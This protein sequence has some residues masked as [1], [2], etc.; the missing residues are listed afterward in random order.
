MVYE[1]KTNTVNDLHSEIKF[2][3]YEEKDLHNTRKKLA[4]SK[5]EKIIKEK[6]YQEA[7]KNLTDLTKFPTNLN[8]ELIKIARQLI[9]VDGVNGP[10]KC[11]K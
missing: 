10:K 8:D 5:Y 1:N 7:K 4:D 11:G 9:L 2:R 6:F 3:S